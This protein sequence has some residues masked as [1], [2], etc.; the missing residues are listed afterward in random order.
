[1]KGFSYQTT[2]LEGFHCFRDF[3][4]SFAAFRVGNDKFEFAVVLIHEAFGKEKPQTME[5]FESDLAK[6]HPGK[7]V[8]QPVGGGILPAGNLYMHWNAWFNK[9]TNRH[10]ANYACP[11]EYLPETDT[12]IL[13]VG[14]AT[15][16]SQNFESTSM[17]CDKDTL[18]T[19]QT[20]M[21]LTGAYANFM[22]GGAKLSDVDALIRQTDLVTFGF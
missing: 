5:E 13:R 2:D 9:W 17:L 15:N 7:T 22:G 6:F 14:I 8:K 4:P 3:G 12:L 1:M 11:L 18:E 16:P 20:F 10:L 19:Y 21:K